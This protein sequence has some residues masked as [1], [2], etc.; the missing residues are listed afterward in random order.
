MFKNNRAFTGLWWKEGTIR[1]NI[2]HQ[3]FKELVAIKISPIK[4]LRYMV[5][6]YRIVENFDG[7]KFDVFDAF[8]LDCQNLTHQIIEKIVQHLQ[9]YRERQSSSVKIFSVKYLKSQYPSKFCTIWYV[10]GSLDGA[11]WHC[12]NDDCSIRIMWDKLLH[13]TTI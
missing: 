1:Q 9:V 3:I 4:I 8:Q 2:F 6:V 10:Y 13:S 11:P 7:G 12:I 5:Y